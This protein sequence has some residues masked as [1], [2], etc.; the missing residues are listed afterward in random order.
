MVIFKFGNISLAIVVRTGLLTT[1]SDPHFRQI[2][3][4]IYIVG[5]PHAA[6]TALP[7]ETSSGVEW[8]RITA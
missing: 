1:E 3:I 8:G 7:P 2:Y 4:E 5:G 6:T